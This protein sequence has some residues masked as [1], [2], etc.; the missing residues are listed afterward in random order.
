MQ[1]FYPMIL[2]NNSFLTEKKNILRIQIDRMVMNEP[3]SRSVQHNAKF[4]FEE[5]GYQ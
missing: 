2:Q 5:Y 4:F 1:N 3:P